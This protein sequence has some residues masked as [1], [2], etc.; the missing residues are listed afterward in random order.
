MAAHEFG[1]AL[2]LGHSQD[3]TALMYPIYQ[4]VNTEGYK[5]PEDDRQGIQVI[6]GE[7]STTSKI[8]L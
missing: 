3:P 4:Y 2:G 8:E 1:H 7:N 6:Y 5:L